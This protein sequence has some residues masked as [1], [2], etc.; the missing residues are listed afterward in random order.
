MDDTKFPFI[1]G[2]ILAVVMVTN[3]FCKL[4]LGNFESWDEISEQT[5]ICKQMM[6]QTNDVASF[7]F[8]SCQNTLGSKT[9][10][11]TIFIGDI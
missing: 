7:Y 6:L 11:C 10:G 4:Y 2:K 5:G 1:F 3:K 9:K 8:V